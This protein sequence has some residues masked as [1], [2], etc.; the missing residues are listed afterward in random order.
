M[1][2]SVV[3]LISDGRGCTRLMTLLQ[4]PARP[5]I[6]PSKLMKIQVTT[7]ERGDNFVFMIR[8]PQSC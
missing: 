1:L 2:A 3:E 7:K 6:S 8:L 5:T 4:F